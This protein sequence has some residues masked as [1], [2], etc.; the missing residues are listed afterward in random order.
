MRALFGDEDI[1]LSSA[2][3]FLPAVCRTCCAVSGCVACCCSNDVSS[4]AG[5][6]SST[7]LGIAGITSVAFGLINRSNLSRHFVVCCDETP[8]HAG[9]PGVSPCCWTRDFV[10]YLLLLLAIGAST[11]SPVGFPLH[12]YECREC[13]SLPLI[14]SRAPPKRPSKLDPDCCL[15]DDL[16]AFIGAT[17][18]RS[19]GPAWFAS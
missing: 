19:R 12:T 15:H 6:G 17:Q 4:P 16:I 7:A 1:G 14:V 13:I 10:V 5:F 18:E 11:A 3:L 8:R 2:P 9:Q